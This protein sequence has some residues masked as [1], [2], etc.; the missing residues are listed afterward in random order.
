MNLSRRHFSLLRQMALLAALSALSLPA[1]AND[2]WVAGTGGTIQA[3]NGEHPSIRMV[4]ETVRMD[5]YA[6]DYQTTVDFEFQ[7]TGS[8]TTVQMGFPE[9]GYIGV[10][11]PEA[12]RKAARKTYY[13]NFMT[14]VDGR[15]T[16]ATRQQAT[17]KDGDYTAYWT[18][19]VRF[20][21]GQTRKVQVTYRSPYGGTAFGT[22]HTFANYDFTGGN[23]KGKVD[24]SRL[25]IT[26]HQPGAFAAYGQLDHEKDVIFQQRGSTLTT[27][28]KNWE[29]QALFSINL[30]TS[31]PDFRPGNSGI[32]MATEDIWKPALVYAI[33]NPG[34]ATDQ[35]G[36]DFLPTTLTYNGILYVKAADLDDLLFPKPGKRSAS[37]DVINVEL[38][39]DPTKRHASVSVRGKT[40]GF[41]TSAPA[42]ATNGRLKTAPNQAFVL[43]TFMRQFRLYV[44]LTPIVDGLGGKIILMA[45]GQV[46]VS[47]PASART[48]SQ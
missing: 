26:F 25:I 13:K 33:H 6:N 12:E 36:Y 30:G 43:P 35:Q 14:S 9:S 34:G 32:R 38:A 19:S 23:W 8:A 40:F 28:W 24:E 16:P 31:T 21:T 22:L 44:P 18:K 47:L 48:A 42:F 1:F 41:E 20:G 7:N 15:K 2:T 37:R 11:G 46:R 5:L 39:Y 3:M 10:D 17:V 45:D 27:V 4:R 29:A